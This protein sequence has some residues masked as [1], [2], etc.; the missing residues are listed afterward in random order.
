MSISSDIRLK[1]KI[2]KNLNK[3]KKD[4]FDDGG[5]ISAI[6]GYVADMQ[7]EFSQL[8]VS[9][10]RS[11]IVSSL[12]EYREP[13]QHSD[14]DLETADNYMDR[15]ISALQREIAALRRAL[16]AARRAREALSGN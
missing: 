6:N 9:D 4:L 13:S 8:I 3:Y 11:H 14:S 5:D 16:E 1:E 2:V 7:E 15:E 10:N 12:S